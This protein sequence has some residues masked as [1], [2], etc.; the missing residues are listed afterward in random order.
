MKITS[1]H[2]LATSAHDPWIERY[3]RYVQHECDRLGGGQI[4]QHYLRY[5]S[6]AYA[7]FLVAPTQP[8]RYRVWLEPNC[9]NSQVCAPFPSLP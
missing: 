1:Y 2:D 6:G 7:D 3:I 9:N 8:A 4:G 5:I